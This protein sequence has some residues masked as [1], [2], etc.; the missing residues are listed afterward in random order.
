MRTHTK[1]TRFS[2]FVRVGFLICF[3]AAASWLLQYSEPSKHQASAVFNKIGRLRT[4]SIQE[5]PHQVSKRNRFARWKCQEFSKENINACSTL[6]I[7]CCKRIYMKGRGFAYPVQ[8]KKKRR[9]RFPIMP[10]VM[11]SFT[12]KL[13][14]KTA[15]DRL[16]E[17]PNCTTQFICTSATPATYPSHYWI[18]Q[19]QGCIWSGWSYSILP[20]S[21][22]HP[23][24]FT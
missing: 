13:N 6:L 8:N 19:I 3:Y 21:V 14:Q 23:Q 5:A 15:Q 20:L 7:W 2:D 22:V 17:L 16:R 12:Q 11:I 4:A 1:N 18:I 24:G 9:K 10:N